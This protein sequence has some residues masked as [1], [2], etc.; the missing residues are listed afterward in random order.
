[1]ANKL[2]NGHILSPDFLLSHRLSSAKVVE[3]Y[4]FE[5]GYYLEHYYDKMDIH[6]H[7]SYEPIT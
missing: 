2:G 7:Q 3:K 5:L 6:N 4:N 1:M